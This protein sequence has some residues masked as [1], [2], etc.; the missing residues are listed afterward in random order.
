M[1]KKQVFTSK[2]EA[3][4]ALWDNDSPFKQ[5]VVQDKRKYSRKVKHKKGSNDPF[6]LSL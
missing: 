2:R 1:S 4:R 3:N 6:S 5:K